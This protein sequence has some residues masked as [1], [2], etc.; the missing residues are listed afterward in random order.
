MY[1]DLER[2]PLRADA[3]ARALAPD[4]WQVEVVAKATSTN[5]LVAERARG[6]AGPGL[7]VIAEHQSAGRG[8]QDRIWCSPP[9]AGLTFSALVAR[10]EPVTWMPL[11]A[12]LA[13]A[14]TL[15]EQAGL[16]AV[17]KWPNDVLVGGRK[18]CGL[19]TEVVGSAVV[20]GIGLNV[21]TRPDELAVPEATSLQIAGSASTDRDPMLRAV[22]RSLTQVLA[23][24]S[25][26]GY[27]ALCTTLGREVTVELP[28]G[29]SVRGVA[30]AVDD[31]G[32]LVVAGV[33]HAAGDVRHVR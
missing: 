8:R 22:L 1:D 29:A 27:R 15:R 25:P 30:E 19:L 21:T 10:Q 23:D 17:L 13:V 20:I 33:A 3:L 26:E 28:G 9:R 7:V 31:Q 6:G 11:L 12:G 2:P 32:R 16:D 14:R 24:P 4:G 5:A 18:V